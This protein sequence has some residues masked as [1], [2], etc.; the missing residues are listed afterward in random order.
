M[1]NDFKPGYQFVDTATGERLPI[2]N[3]EREDGS[4]TTVVFSEQEVLDALK[5]RCGDG[6]YDK[7]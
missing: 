5:E 4:G 7:L 3:I 2:L 1:I 6:L